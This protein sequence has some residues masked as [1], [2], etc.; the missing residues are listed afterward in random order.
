MLGDHD[1]VAFYHE[2]AIAKG[3][4]DHTPHVVRHSFVTTLVRGGRQPTSPA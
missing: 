2:Q 3:L 1:G 4:D